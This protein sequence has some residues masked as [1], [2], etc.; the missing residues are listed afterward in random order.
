MPSPSWSSPYSSGPMTWT[1]PVYAGPLPLPPA[2]STSLAKGTHGSYD[3]WQSPAG[4]GGGGGVGGGAG[5]GGGRGSA[6]VGGG[7][8]GGGARV[9]V[10]GLV[11]GVRVVVELVLVPPVA[12][13]SDA[14]A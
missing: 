13:S 11:D 5:T 14:L 1:R 10:V 7:A 6:L 4:T 9:V 12:A 8:G 3:G 2:Q